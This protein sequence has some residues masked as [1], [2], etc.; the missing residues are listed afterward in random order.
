MLIN[1]SNLGTA[2]KGF[3]AVYQD[4]FDNAPVY[5]PKI[6]MEIPSSSR[7][8][9]YGWLGN[10]PQLR[11]WLDGERVV[12]QLA[13]HGFTITNRKFESTVSISR[14]D[15]AD[16]RYG[17]FT[18]MFGEMGALA[19]Q[20]PDTLIFEMLGTGFQ[21][22]AYDGQNFF[23]AEHPTVDKNGTANFTS[24][25]QAGTDP[26]WYLLD[27]SRAIKPIIWQMRERYDMQSVFAPN[28][29]HVFLKDQYL[30]GVRAR[31][32]SG[33]G[34]WQLAYGSKAPLTKENYEAA[35]TAMQKVRGDT[36]RLLGVK[37]DTIVVSAELEGEARRLL[38]ATVGGGD[39]N[40]W[41]GTAEIIVAPYLD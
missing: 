6:A 19:K 20:H 14:D 40:E 31:V 38:K 23:D 29:P 21:N 10:F 15:Y 13:A 33:F 4:S 26:A 1:E 34:L 39:T 36:G 32:N 5:W 9:D 7:S 22:V 25:V 11:E 18:P 35:R 28:D 30:Y 12:K 37:P 41:A 27:T 3:K 8:E 24:N 2:F 17:I 16:D